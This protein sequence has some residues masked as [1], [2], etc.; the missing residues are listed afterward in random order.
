MA[1]TVAEEQENGEV[2]VVPARRAITIRDLLTHTAG[3]GYWFSDR[4]AAHGDPVAGARQGFGVKGWY[5]ADLDEPMRETVRR[6]AAVP[7]NGHPGEAFVYGYA[8]DVLGALVEVVSGEPLDLFL[9][10]RLFGPLDMPDTHFYLP[11]EKADRLATVYGLREGVLSRA[12]DGSGREA[13]GDYVEGPRK[14][15]SG[16]AGLLS[17]ARDYARFIQ[18][19][20]NGGELEGARILSPKSV[21]LMTANH[22]GDLMSPGAGFGLG[23][24]TVVDLGARGILGSQGEFAWSGAY[25]TLYWGDSTEDLVVVYMTQVIPAT[26]LDDHAKLRALVYQAIT[27]S[28]GGTGGR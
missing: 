5:F 12:P 16:G 25:R 22:V 2:R 7:F 9:R 28:Y 8:T 26:G 20:V 11:P 21:E 24:Q 17:T 23:F 27:E 4:P 14:S 15:L 3:L 6:M 19:I 18:A 1:T 13:Q 10:T